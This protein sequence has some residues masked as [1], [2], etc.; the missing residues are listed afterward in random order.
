[1]A[2]G[3][4][5]LTWECKLLVLRQVEVGRPLAQAAGSARVAMLSL[6]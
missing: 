3:G 1:L 4:H 2:L 6:N 5:G